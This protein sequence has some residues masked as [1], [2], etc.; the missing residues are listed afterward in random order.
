[1]NREPVAIV[2]AV[3]LALLAAI[4]FG[5]KLTDAQLIAT[6]AALEAALTLLVRQQVTPN[7]TAAERAEVAAR[8]GGLPA[9]GLVVVP[10]D[11]ADR[12]QATTLVVVVLLIVIILLATGRL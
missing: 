2:N 10:V 8:L 9:E 12:G 4:T 5:L 7:A 6:M 3:R 11:D 1:M